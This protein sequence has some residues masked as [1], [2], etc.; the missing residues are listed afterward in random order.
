LIISSSP[1]KTNGMDR[2]V[3]KDKKLPEPTMIGRVSVKSSRDFEF[4]LLGQV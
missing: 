4:L 2:K 1:L 3:V